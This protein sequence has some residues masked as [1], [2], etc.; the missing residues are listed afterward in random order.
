MRDMMAVLS[1]TLLT[2]VCWGVYGPVILQGQGAME[3]SRLRPFICVGLAYF[4]IAVIAPVA[5]LKSK[6]EKGS[7]TTTGFIWS[8]AAGALGALGALGI[9]L[10]FSFHGQPVFV[11]PLVFGLAPVVNTFTAMYFGRSFKQIG[12]AFLAGMILVALGAVVVLIAKPHPR[13]VEVEDGAITVVLERDEAGEPSKTIVA[14][15]EELA[16]S[17]NADFQKANKKYLRYKQGKM[18]ALDYL[19]VPLFIAMTA[20]CWGAYGPVL[21]K[22]QVAMEGSRLRPLICVGLAYFAIAV[23]VPFAILNTLEPEGVFTASGV[24]WSLGGGAAGAFGA[25]GIILA[26]NFGG[27]PVYVMPLVFGCAPVINAFTEIIGRS[28][29]EQIGPLFYA[30]LIIVLAGAVIVLVFAPKGGP[31]P[32]PAAKPDPLA[33][34]L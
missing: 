7:W 28:L 31:H 15:E 24:L 20:I 30:G 13:D 34:K 12:P 33:S 14:T 6:G 18:A 10:A 4:V 9:V 27:K 11:M 23:A 1:A 22:G 26:F 5:M 29:Y 25:L 3:G 8:F 21:H 16:T 19:W 17:D 2:A 32:A